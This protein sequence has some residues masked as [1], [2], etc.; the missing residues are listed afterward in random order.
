VAERSLCHQHAAAVDHQL[1]RVDQGADAEGLD[2]HEVP[3]LRGHVIDGS[4][5][6]VLRTWVTL[7]TMAAGSSPG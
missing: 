4:G 6:A 2:R 1:D 3:L 5:A 7:V